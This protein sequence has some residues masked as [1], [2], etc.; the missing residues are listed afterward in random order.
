MNNLYRRQFLKIS[1]G[2]INAVA[3]AGCCHAL[4]LLQVR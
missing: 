2:T 4:T 3:V 1:T